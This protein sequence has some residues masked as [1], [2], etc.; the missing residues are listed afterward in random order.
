[1]G[2]DWCPLQPESNRRDL[3]QGAES[4]ACSLFRGQK[5]RSEKKR[6][7]GGESGELKYLATVLP[8]GNLC[9][10]RQKVG[11]YFKTTHLAQLYTDP[12]R[13]W[14]FTQQ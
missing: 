14:L 6:G 2:E 3:V 12:S 7:A 5:R 8:L 10:G 9:W 13:Q 1:M 4:V 11:F